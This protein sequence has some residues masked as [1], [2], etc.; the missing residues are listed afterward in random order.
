MSKN[1][2]VVYDT[3]SGSTGGVAQFIEDTLLESGAQVTVASVDMVE[4]VGAYDAVFI[5]SPLISGKIMSG[6]KGFVSLNNQSLSKKPVAFFTT[7][8]R[9]GQEAGA[10]IPDIPVFVD[11]SFGNPKPKSEMSFLEKNHLVAAYMKGIS[12]TAMDIEPIGVSFS[13]ACWTI[14][15]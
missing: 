1:V 3:K 8:L 14:A 6:I 13:R 11:P 7:C 15:R 12:E 10:W 9:I 5:G 4:N 2:L